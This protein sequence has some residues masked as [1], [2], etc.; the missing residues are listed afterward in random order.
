MIFVS[1]IEDDDDIR[2]G[3]R[4]LL[5]G[6]AD[7]TCV[8]AYKDCESAIKDIYKK[9]PDVLLL[10]IE[11]P[12]MSGIE[13]VP[14]IKQLVPDVDIVMLTVHQEDKLIFDSLCAGA[15]GYLVKTIPPKKLIAAIEEVYNGGAPM[16][17]HIARRVIHSFKKTTPASLT[18]REKE[19]LSLLCD[20][21]SYKMIG[22]ELGISR[23]TVH[24]HI[25]NIYKKLHVHSNAEAVAKALRENLV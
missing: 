18:G 22:G 25:K 4:L 12:G 11:L 1:I 5:D 3:L 9:Q 6:A 7:I 15:C 16:S 21:N 14:K 8:S 17:A 10:D 23:G 24:C 13:G 2:Q 19:I 20:G